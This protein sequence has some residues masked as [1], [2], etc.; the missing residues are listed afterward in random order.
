MNKQ[1]WLGV[2][3]AAR[4]INVSERNLRRYLAENRVLAYKDSHCW[5][6]PILEINGQVYILLDNQ[7]YRKTRKIF[8]RS[9]H[10]RRDE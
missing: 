9:N 6:I 10:S 4:A 3:E 2:R 8:R 5:R 1:Q 7:P